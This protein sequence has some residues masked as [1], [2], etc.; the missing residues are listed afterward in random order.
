MQ[1]VAS[2][3]ACYNSIVSKKNQLLL[4]GLKSIHLITI[5]PWKEVCYYSMSHYIFMG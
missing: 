3:N 1:E 4:L 2:E 5:K